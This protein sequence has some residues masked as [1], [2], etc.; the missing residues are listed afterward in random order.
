MSSTDAQKA[1]MRPGRSF[2]DQALFFALMGSMACTFL[3]LGDK[4]FDHIEVE[5][6]GAASDVL[7]GSEQQ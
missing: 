4:M 6:Q 3:L 1:A 5:H 2:V 7:A